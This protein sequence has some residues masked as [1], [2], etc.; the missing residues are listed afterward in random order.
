MNARKIFKTS[1]ALALILIL[2]VTSL[3]L[4][5]DISNDLDVTVDAT[6]EVMNRTV[7]GGNGT[8]NFYLIPINDD[9]K[10]GCNLTGQL[11]L[12]LSVISSN[13][14]IATV[15]PTE[16]TFSSCGDKIPVS[17]TPVA[18]GSVIVSLSLFSTDA[19]GTFDLLPASFTVNV[20]AAA[21][22]TNTPPSIS[23]TD[24]TDGTSYEIGSVPVAGCN[25]VDAEDGN[26]TFA[27]TLSAISG[28]QS[29]YGIG[30][31]TASCSYTDT[32]GLSA[33]ASATYS[34]VDTTLPTLHL[35]DDMT[36]EAAGP[37]GAVVTFSA[38]ADD[39]DPVNPVV[40]CLPVS[41]STFA[42]G[43]TTVSCS[44]TD[45]A[46]NTANGSF[47][48][49]VQD[50]T[51]PII[52][53][54]SR[55]PA[56]NAYGWNNSA[57]TV[58]WSCSDLVGVVSASVSE[59]V[60]TEGADQSATGTCQDNYGNEASDTQ[61]D[62]N[63]DLTAPTA[64]ASALPAPNAFG[65][66]NTDVTVSFSGEDSL[67]GIDFCGAA[68][69]LSSEVAGQSAS[70][71]CTDKAG[72]VSELATASGIN[73]DKTAPTI[74]WIGSINNGETF[75]F[76]FVPPEPACTAND[77]LS[78]EKGCT[79]TGYGTTIGSHTLTA[80]A[81]DLAGNKKEETRSYTV[82]AWSFGGFYQPVDMGGVLNTVKGG[83]TV[84]FKFEVFAGPTELTDIN[85]I[86]GFSAAPIVCAPNAIADAIEVT[87][88]GGTSLRYDISAGQFVYNWQTPKKPGACY[89]VK[90][91][92]QDGSS[93]FANFKL[94]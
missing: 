59:T 71:T 77:S 12:V 3:V 24:V 73:I 90:M 7:G 81:Y 30:S 35:P 23:V 20:A 54:V 6:L 60:S 42:L 86:V 70:G 27:A 40:S 92:T 26:S 37:S 10:Q 21:T 83:S 87:S 13:K 2:F 25:V 76:G 50:T 9:G 8:V 14:D 85:Y 31:Q 94:K 28:P 38:I 65:W 74:T 15:S 58:N 41:G 89:Q 32:G 80:T 53:F 43:T 69:V 52:T 78:G 57:V 68:V 34:I 4:A 84:P 82:S 93:L 16:I 19:K 39:V 46:G 75:Y 22:P 45:T 61:T 79:V 33:F 67:S 17:V 18:A 49:T 88:T 36:V 51:P 11:T 64:N 44:A 1:V 48:V 62:I 72:N 56:A 91:T 66:N 63:I 47:N 55:M 5:D 29:A